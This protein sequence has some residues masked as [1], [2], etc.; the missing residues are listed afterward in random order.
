[1]EHLRTVLFGMS[2]NGHAV[3]VANS[4]RTSNAFWGKLKSEVV[5]PNIIHIDHDKP[6]AFSYLSLLANADTVLV[7][8]DSMS[9]LWEAS[10]TNK[11]VFA[12]VPWSGRGPTPEPQARNL[13]IL[14]R[15]GRVIPFS[16]LMDAAP[17]TS[18]R[19]L[20]FSAEFAKVTLERV[21]HWRSSRQV[22]QTFSKEPESQLIF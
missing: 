1:M 8:A 2:N 5:S 7:C 3:F 12:L 4:R 6:G 17:K 11:P 16:Q 15:D 22:K 18:N 20:D 10:A 19:P 13:E 14:L 21:K 9:M